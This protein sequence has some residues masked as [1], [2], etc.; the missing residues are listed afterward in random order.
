MRKHLIVFIVIV[1]IFFN[2]CGDEN[3]KIHSP[4]KELMQIYKGNVTF[5]DD[6]LAEL[7]ECRSAVL[8]LTGRLQ[9]QVMSY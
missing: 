9:S 4:Q 5:V 8:Y 2:A 6:L 3:E 1:T 7:P